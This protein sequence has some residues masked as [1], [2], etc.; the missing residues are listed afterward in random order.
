[1]GIDGVDAEEC[2]RKGEEGG[3]EAALS[4]S[5]V[6]LLRFWLYQ[7]VAFIGEEA[8][9]HSPGEEGGCS[10]FERSA[11]DVR[12]IDSAEEVDDGGV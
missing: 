3:D 9:E 6:E 7:R 10:C 8:E 11:G 4:G 5:Q 1:M 2:Q 12:E